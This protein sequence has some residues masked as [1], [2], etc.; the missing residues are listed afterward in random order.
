MGFEFDA[1]QLTMNLQ[2][3]RQRMA[4]TGKR[5]AV[6][7]GARVIGAAMTERAPVLDK[8]T[9]QSTSLDPGD[10]KANIKV[11]SRTESNGEIVGLVGPKGK[12]G[13]IGKVAYNV[14]YGHRIVTGGQSRL[15]LDGIFRGR[16]RADG[17]FE[18]AGTVIGDVPE[19]QFL[20]P[21]FEAS[22][23]GAIEAMG[24]AL[25]KTLR[26]ESGDE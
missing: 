9:A 13:R 19:H 2:K 10:L 4:T 11:R 17:T 18:P 21:A 16:K 5:R 1:S 12:E 6:I 24:A 8:T 25:A 20:R 22:A 3:L 7:A 26:G 14:E 23:S 15:G